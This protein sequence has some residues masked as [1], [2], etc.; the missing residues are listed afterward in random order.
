MTGVGLYPHLA[1]VRQPI[2]QLCAEVG[3]HDAV[4]AYVHN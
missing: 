4:A 1:D 3:G 2:Q